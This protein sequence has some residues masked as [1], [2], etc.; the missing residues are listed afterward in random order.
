MFNFDSLYPLM[1]EH[2]LS[3][4]AD[5]LP[6]QLDALFSNPHGKL[7]HWI[8]SYL[9]LT[10]ENS[11]AY[12]L[13]DVIK[14]TADYADKYLNSEQLKSLLKEFLPWRK[15][16]FQI[17]DVFIDTEWHSDWKWQ[18]LIEHISPLEN[19]TVLDVGCGNGYHCWRM[20]GAGA[21]L[22]VGIDP[23]F[24][25]LMQFQIFKHFMGEK[26]VY[27]LPMGI[28]LLPANLNAF[29]T[30][31]SM[32]VFYHRRSPMDHLLQLKEALR[33]GGELILETLVIEGEQGQCLVP[34][35]RYAKMRN[36]WFIPSIKTLKQWMARCGLKDISIVDC[37]QTSI[38][39]QRK[40]EWMINESLADFLDPNNIDLT[41][42]GYP[43]PRRVIVVAKK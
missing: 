14:I 3:P 18:R 28:E 27:L 20:Y 5:V 19:R 16:P 41:I 4:W 10:Q 39:E 7:Q 1:H 30:V 6:A 43:A 23:A 9:T 32:G 24:L 13:N 34:D 21:K 11:C 29:D 37:N 15:G 38:Q 25:F 33:P 2:G 22:V 36:V 40:T 8:D 35:G 31:F 42:E 17:N 12:D 26:P